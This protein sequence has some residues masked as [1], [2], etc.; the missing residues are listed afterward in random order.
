MFRPKE[1]EGNPARP[2]FPSLLECDPSIHD[3]LDRIVLRYP[4]NIIGKTI[5]LI[6]LIV[7]MTLVQQGLS[8]I[9]TDPDMVVTGIVIATLGLFVG[10][11]V[12]VVIRR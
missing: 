3:I 11:A 5:G 1:S 6:M 2:Q 7:G 4:A 8:E 9:P 10:V 12:P